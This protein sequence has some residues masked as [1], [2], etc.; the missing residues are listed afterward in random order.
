MVG[1]N[2]KNY[3]SLAIICSPVTCAKCGAWSHA[4]AEIDKCHI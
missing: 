3:W 1:E 4:L 2:T